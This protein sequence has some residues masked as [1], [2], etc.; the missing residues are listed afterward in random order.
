MSMAKMRA[1]MKN[2]IAG[3]CLISRGARSRYPVVAG[4]GLLVLGRAAAWW[5]RARGGELWRKTKE[6]LLSR[7]KSCRG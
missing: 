1:G 7:K 3:A 5:Q 2:R 6:R 4:S